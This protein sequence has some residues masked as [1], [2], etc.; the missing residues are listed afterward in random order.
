M[1]DDKS[2]VYTLF[3]FI[4]L[5]SIFLCCQSECQTVSTVA[6]CSQQRF[7][8]YSSICLIRYCLVVFN[9]SK[10]L[11]VLHSRPKGHGDLLSLQIIQ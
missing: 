2:R 6:W 10:T 5:K 1:E 9:S 4:F 8:N 7:A 11:Y 3:F